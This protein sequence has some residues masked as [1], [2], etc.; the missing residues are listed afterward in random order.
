MPQHRCLL[1][2][3]HAPE[4]LSPRI[5]IQQDLDDIVNVALSVHPS[6]DCKPHQFHGWGN[7]L[8]R[9]VVLAKH[10]AT[11]FHRSDAA[12]S[13]KLHN[14]RLARILLRRDMRQEPLGIQIDGVST[15]RFDDGHPPCNNWNVS[16]KGQ[17]M[18]K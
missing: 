18:F 13:E 12:R 15:W 1:Y 5:H 7:K 11:D 4:F 6:G 14:D 17:N 2:N 3:P 9:F 10:D 8:A 16:T